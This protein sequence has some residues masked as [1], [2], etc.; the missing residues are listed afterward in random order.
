M[1]VKDV[2]GSKYTKE[3][4]GKDLMQWMMDRFDMTRAEAL[5]SMKEH[6]HTLEEDKSGGSVGRK[7]GG[8]VSRR[9]GSAVVSNNINKSIPYPRKFPDDP[10]AAHPDYSYLDFDSD[11]IR[12]IKKKKK[13]PEKK[14][15]GKKGPNWHRSKRGG[16]KI[17]QGYKA[18]GKV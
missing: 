10:S 13:K 14:G 16:S 17:M 12:N 3:V 18:G 9:K 7:K 8:I 4:T 6:G 5:A 11:D 1:A 15:S 2:E